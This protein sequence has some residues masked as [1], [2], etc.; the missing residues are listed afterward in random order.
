MLKKNTNYYLGA[1]VGGLVIAKYVY[2]NYAF[3]TW[4]NNPRVGF[5]T[6]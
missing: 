1:K 3:W 6:H 5:S 2:F 4:G